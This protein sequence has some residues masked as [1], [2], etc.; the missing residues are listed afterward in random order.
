MR[1]RVKA[2][3]PIPTPKPK[4]NTHPTHTYVW[5]G[6]GLW[7]LIVPIGVDGFFLGLRCSLHTLVN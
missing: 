2:T 5:V 6:W 4:M 7:P 1:P 3:R